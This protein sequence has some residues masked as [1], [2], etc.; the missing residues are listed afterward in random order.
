MSGAY[1]S[2][3]HVFG[4]RSLPTQKLKAR[5]RNPNRFF[6]KPQKL[7]VRGPLDGRRC[8]PD[9]EARRLA[10]GPDHFGAGGSGLGMDFQNASFRGVLNPFG[11]FLGR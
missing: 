4:S 7:F 3:D 5:S 1:A 9:L 2:A 8:D 6:E 11:E 10:M